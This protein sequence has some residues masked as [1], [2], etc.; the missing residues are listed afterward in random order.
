[1]DINRALKMAVTTGKVHFGVNQALRSAEEGK[2]KLFIQASNFPEKEREKFDSM[3]IPHYSFNGNNFELG[4][5]CG[6]P[7]SVS[8]LSIVEPGESDIMD[9]I[10]PE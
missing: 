3:G 4:A 10:P 6:K 8:V 1:M 7:F 9:L 2:I 5:V